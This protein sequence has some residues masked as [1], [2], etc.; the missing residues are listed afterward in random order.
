M[1]RSDDF[2]LIIGQI[3]SQVS[4]RMVQLGLIWFI[5][6]NFG[7]SFLIWYL[8]TGG[9]PHLLL[10]KHSSLIIAKLSSLKTVLYA[11]FARGL[12]YLVAFSLV[13]V[14]PE[15]LDVKSGSKVLW[16]LFT[17][18]FAA[19]VF[20][21]FFNPSILALAVEIKEKDEI[22]KLTAKLS[23]ITSFATILGPIIGLFVFDQLGLKGLFVITGISYLVSAYSI[24]LMTKKSSPIPLETAELAAT[25][26]PFSVFQSHTIIGVMLIIFL[27]INLMLSPIQILM[28]SMSKE[29][30][31]NSFNA[32]A[33]LET[34]LGA[35]ILL[36]GTVLSFFSINRKPL[37][38]AWIYLSTM[39]FAFLSFT[40]A[41]TL[42]EQSISFIASSASL[43]ALGFF[44]GLA[45]VLILNIL[46]TQPNPAD[47]PKVMSYVN[48]ISTA[49]LPFSLAILGL[50]Q[51]S[52]PILSL[53]RIS[54]FLLVCITLVAFFPFRRYG[55]EIFK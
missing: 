21:A 39:S 26:T 55:R 25:A 45:N 35:G 23:S 18:V 6:S 16:L 27:M 48:L 1:K 28:P 15:W 13:L 11:D 53:G 41:G 22:Q 40:L 3:L 42:G 2:L 12:I 47:V 38:W 32:L 34:V 10:V 46:Q 43:L 50:L 4:D 8:V 19:N 9:L 29:L 36:G 37:F 7:E 14:F 51:Q 24:S 44:L 52:T 17:S 30:F 20:S 31:G 33:I 54:G 49:T 5:T